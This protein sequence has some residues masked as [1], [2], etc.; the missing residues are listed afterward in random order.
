MQVPH[1]LQLRLTGKRDLA[2]RRRPGPSLRA[3]Q[4]VEHANVRVP[5]TIRSRHL[6]HPRTSGAI[7]APIPDDRRR[8]RR[9][10]RPPRSPQ[11]RARRCRHCRHR[12]S[13]C[14]AMA[15]D[16]RSAEAKSRFAFNEIEAGV[17]EDHH[18]ADGYDA[19][20]LIRWGDP[21]LP[22]A[23]LRSDE[24]DGGR[25]AAAVRLQQRLSRLFPDPWC[26]QRRSTACS[27][28]ITNTRMKN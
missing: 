16:R 28:S 5:D 2:V 26:G 13:A 8:H 24:A 15:A 18:V 17:D 4:P 21:V 3:I 9:A 12:G 14:P 19:D 20:V 27:S 22:G 25:A 7:S 23:G 6:R 11:G 10:V 1:D